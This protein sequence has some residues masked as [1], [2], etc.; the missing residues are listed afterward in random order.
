MGRAYVCSREMTMARSA[1]P[2]PRTI[3]LFFVGV[4]LV[5][6]GCEKTREVVHDLSKPTSTTGSASA[7]PAPIADAGVAPASLADASTPDA[8]KGKVAN[9][10]VA[11][12]STAKKS[13]Q[14]PLN[15]LPAGAVCVQGAEG[16]GGCASGSECTNG[17]CA[18][19]YGWTSCGGACRDLSRD[20]YNCDKCGH[21]CQ[22]GQYCKWGHC[23]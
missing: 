17:K 13:K 6:S 3:S 5:G 23:E 9:A 19:Y 18:C 11:P 21:E 8:G 14:E 12:P 20:P 4:V 22:F 10:K 16:N 15:G 7:T 2:L 1:R